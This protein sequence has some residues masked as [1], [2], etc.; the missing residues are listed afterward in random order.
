MDTTMKPDETCDKALSDTPIHGDPSPARSESESPQVYESET[1]LKGGR[2]IL[3]RHH[4]EVYRL[5]LTRN[6][7]LILNK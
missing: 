7:K 1:L 6:D 2:E 5:R 4:G 3:I